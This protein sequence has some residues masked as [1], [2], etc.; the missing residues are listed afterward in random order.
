MADIRK[1]IIFRDLILILQW[2]IVPHVEIIQREIH[3]SRVLLQE[4]VIMRESFHTQY[5]VFRQFG[6]FIFAPTFHSFLIR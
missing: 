4:K 6:D 2:N 5:Q 3:N 1:Q